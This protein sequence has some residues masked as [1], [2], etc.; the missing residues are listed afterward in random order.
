MEIGNIKFWYHPITGGS[1]V[2]Y[3]MEYYFGFKF[4]MYDKKIIDTTKKNII[5]FLWEP[6]NEHTI[7]F[8]FKTNKFEFFELIKEMNNLGFYFL[9]DYSTES[10]SEIDEE[11]V[12][13][14]SKLKRININIDKFY[15]VTN[16]SNINQSKLKY[17]EHLINHIH[18]PYFLSVTP[19]EMNKYLRELD[20]YKTN[21]PSK[22]FICLNRRVH[23]HKFNFLKKL[24]KRGLLEK[25]NW[26]WVCN[27]IDLKDYRDDDFVKYLNI[28]VNNFNS[29]Q[30]TD[31]V[32]YG[33]K[34]DKADEFL[35]T[36]NPKWFYESK[37][38]LI[39]E[40]NPF[41][42]PLHLTEKTFKSIF[43]GVPFV[44]FGSKGHLEKLKEFGF[45]V[46]ESVIGEYNCTDEDSVID[47]GMRLSKIYD[48]ESVVKICKENQLK[49]KSFDTHK[50]II[51]KYFISRFQTK[52]I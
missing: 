28:D 4:T 23:R 41:N 1:G 40:S 25:T 21:Q 6:K 8:E 27:Y 30:L 52:M 14:I 50:K 7:N 3:L 15:L 42:R 22:E 17:G 18:F 49:L 16:N 34:L 19:I 32:M 5:V 38:N 35:Y 36:I 33:T 29:F 10:N 43:L 44:I 31:D 24:W 48:S 45:D 51:Q 37:V 11:R 47:A 9:A 12:N 2:Q 26:T 13:F 39:V 20:S 46:F